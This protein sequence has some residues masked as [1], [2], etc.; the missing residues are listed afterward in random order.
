MT[1]HRMVRTGVVEENGTGGRR[2]RNEFG[3]GTFLSLA[4]YGEVDRA[5]WA[6]RGPAVLGC[7]RYRSHGHPGDGAKGLEV[8]GHHLPIASQDCGSLLF[9]DFSTPAAGS[10]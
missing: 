9:L 7:D 10:S 3:I 8:L 2:R 6:S 4:E 1:N 5:G